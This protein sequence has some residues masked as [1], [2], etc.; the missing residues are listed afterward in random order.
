MLRRNGNVDLMVQFSDRRGLRQAGVGVL[1]TSKKTCIK[2]GLHL[3]GNLYHL[4]NRQRTAAD[5]DFADRVGNTDP[6]AL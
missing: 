4:F 2:K 3:A 5:A 1:E 6:L